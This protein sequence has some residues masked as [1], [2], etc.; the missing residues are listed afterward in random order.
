M[1]SRF[2]R[3]A[4]FPPEHDGGAIM[5]KCFNGNYRLE[6]RILFEAAAA[7]EIMDTAENDSPN[8]NTNET[9]QQARDEKD[10]LKNAPP[11]NMPD[12]SA[13]T[14]AA[15]PDK[16]G[17]IDA[18]VKEM[19]QGEIPLSG[20]GL[21]DAD[22]EQLVSDLFARDRIQNS[23]Q[24]QV[25]DS[26]NTVSTGKELV[27]ISS[28]LSGKDTI[29]AQAGPN[30][31]VLVLEKGSDGMQQIL[32]YLANSETRYDA[33]HFATKGNDGYFTVNDQRIDAESFDANTWSQIGSHLTD[34]GDLL[35]YGCNLAKSEAGQNL[36]S[37][38]ADASGADVAASTDVTG[39]DGN[40]ELEYSIGEINADTISVDGYGFNLDSVTTE[41]ELRTAI[42]SGQ[43]VITIDGDFTISDTI[44]INYSL[45]IDSSDDYTLT[46]NGALGSNMFQI[47]TSG[48]T[49]DISG[50]TLDGGAAYDSAGVA[51]D[52]A[53]LVSV[54]HVNAHVDFHNV[55][56]TNGYADGNGGAIT[57]SGSMTLEDCDFIG[58]AAKTHGG[59][60]YTTADLTLNDCDF[61]G[62]R[63]L[64]QVTGNTGVA[65]AIYFNTA[66]GRFIINDGLFQD[67]RTELGAGGALYTKG[68]IDITG[69]RFIDNSAAAA[70]GA[71]FNLGTLTISGATF[72][73]NS[74]ATNG[75]AISS[76]ATVDLTGGTTFSGN[77]ATGNGGV[78]YLYGTGTLDITGTANLFQDNTAKSGGAIYAR[79]D[80]SLNIG[81]SGHVFSS[82]S[83]NTGG[84]IYL[85]ST[86]AVSIEGASFLSNRSTANHGGAIYSYND[87]TLKNSTFSS[88]QA[89]ETDGSGGA[90][91]MN[92]DTVLSFDGINTFDGNRAV[93]GGAIYLS[94]GAV[95]DI[96]SNT[97]TF[98]GNIASKNGG[99]IF[100]AGN[101][102]V[103]GYTFS[104]LVNSGNSA[105]FGG[106]FHNA[107]TLTV[108]A[109]AFS[110]ITVT[111]NG[112]VIYNT[113]TLNLNDGTVFS[114][115]TASYG[116]AIFST[117]GPVS[118]TG[119]ILFSGNSATVFG[120]AVY[121]SVGSSLTLSDNRVV[122]TGNTAEDGGA[123]FN[124][125]TL[126]VSNYTFS[127]TEN[128]GNSA[129]HGGV[130]YNKG[131]LTIINSTFSGSSIT[132]YGGVIYQ[133][134]GTLNLETGTVFSGNSAVHGG[135][136]YHSGGTINFADG[137]IFSGNSATYGGAI[138]V[139]SGA[140]LSLENGKVLFTG[141]SA[142]Y[143]GVACN[144][145]SLTVSSYTF[146]SSVNS[147]NS[148]TNRGG[149]FYNRGVMTVSG[150]SFSDMDITGTGGVI[151]Q[152]AG[153]LTI[154]G[155]TVFLN[156]SASNGGAIFLSG[157]TLDLAGDSIRFDGNTAAQ[158]GGAIYNAGITR[159]NG[160]DI[161]FQG[162]T[163]TAT[164]G[165]AIY[166]TGALTINGSG[167][168]FTDNHA[169][170][171]GVGGS[172]AGGAVFVFG[173]GSF[174]IARGADRT[175]FSRN[176]AGL[177]GGAVYTHGL[178][179]VNGSN[180][181]YTENSADRDGGAVYISN[182][183]TLSM[184]SDAGTTVFENNSARNGGAIFV[185]GK[186]LVLADGTRFTGNTADNAGGAVYLAAGSSFDISDNRFVFTGNTA[187]SGGVICNA[188]TLTVANYTFDG[189]G[190]SGNRAKDGGIFYNDAG[191]KLKIVDSIFSGQ[192][193]TGTGGVIAGS[194]ELEIA[195]GEFSGNSADGYGG[196]VTVGTAGKLTISGNTV[197]RNN[198]AA[199][200]GAIY[201]YGS[202]TD[203]SIDGAVFDSNK[204]LAMHGGAIR[205]EQDLTISNTVFRDNQAQAAGAVGG[206][207]YLT[208]NSKLTLLDNNTFRGNQSLSSRGGAIHITNGSEV[209]ISGRGN[210]FAANKA[211]DGGA[212]YNLGTL[213]IAGISSETVFGGTG[214]A[215]GN[216]AVNGGGAIY[217]MGTLVINNTMFSYNA[218]SGHGGAIYNT[219]NLEIVNA[220]F[221]CNASSGSGGAVYST[222]SYTAANS[223]FTGNKANGT[224]GGALFLNNSAGQL[225]ISDSTFADNETNGYGGAIRSSGKILITGKEATRFTGNSALADGGAIMS[226]GEVLIRADG[227]SFT[228][229]RATRGGAVSLNGSG[230]SLIITGDNT[231]FDQN[232]TVQS[233][234]GAIYAV[235]GTTVSIEGD[236]TLFSGN[237]ASSSGGAAIIYGTLNITGNN[238]GF[239]GNNAQGLGSQGNGGAIYLYA[240]AQGTISG[241]GTYFRGNS[242]ENYG[243]A[244]FNAGNLTITA[245]S[246]TVFEGNFISGRST[247]RLG[248]G[249][250]YTVG[251]LTVDRAEFTGNWA[252]DT[253]GI[254]LYESYGGAIHI[255]G[256][257]A[258]IENSRF[259]DN[260]AGKVQ[261]GGAISVG[262]IETAG[263]RGNATVNHCYFSG[264]HASR[265]GG[266]VSVG[267][268]SLIEAGKASVTN[269]EF[270]QNQSGRHGGAIYIAAGRYSSAGEAVLSE[271]TFTGNYAAKDGGAIYV[272]GKGILSL[273]N[274]GGTASFIDNRAGENGGAVYTANALNLTGVIFQNNSAANGGAVFLAASTE[275]A[276]LANC[277]VTTSSASGEGSAVYVQNGRQVSLDS[278]NLSG[279]GASSSLFTVES[280]A[281]AVFG[282]VVMKTG[283][284][285]GAGE[286]VFNGV[287]NTGTDAAV[288][289][290]SA[291][292]AYAL[293]AGQQYVYEG[294]YDTLHILHAGE[295]ILNGDIAVAS[296]MTVTGDSV[297]AYVILNGRN[298]RV[299][300]GAN[301]LSA[302][303]ARLD[304]LAFSTKQTLRSWD[305]SVSTNRVS[306]NANTN[307]NIVIRADS[308]TGSDLYYGVQLGNTQLA[309]VYSLHGISYTDLNDRFQ[310]DSSETP[311]V[312]RDGSPDGAVLQQTLDRQTTQFDFIYAPEPDNNYSLENSSFDITIRPLDITVTGDSKT[313]TYNGQEQSYSGISANGLMEG[314]T[315]STDA[316]V[317][318]R[319]AG[320]YEYGIANNEVKIVDADGNDVTSNYH[321]ENVESGTL[322]INPA[323]LVFQ[324]DDKHKV[325]GSSDPE[326]T[327]T[328]TEGEL[329]GGD[330]IAGIT[331]EPGESVGK[332]AINGY[333]LQTEHSGNYDVS[334]TP[335]TLTIHPGFIPL[336]V[337]QDAS[338]QEYV[339]N[340]RSAMYR[341]FDRSDAEANRLLPWLKTGVPQIGKVYDGE[342]FLNPRAGDSEFSL[343]G[344]EPEAFS[345]GRTWYDT[346]FRTSGSFEPASNKYSVRPPVMNL[347]S[348]TDRFSGTAASGE[349]GTDD[350]EAWKD[351]GPQ[352]LP[353]IDFYLGKTENCR[354]EFD[355]LLADA[356]GAEAV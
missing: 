291:T 45:T 289:D 213:T 44:R 160:N 307:L 336:N 217:N 48:T 339:V 313:V 37:Q 33:I 30:R 237:K 342:F 312:K 63:S 5:K 171:K 330:T 114:G 102:T 246:G 248:G 258:L 274:T 85:N 236:N 335:G 207:V 192:H 118:M 284:N 20:H 27:I 208:S 49:V 343:G 164:H 119:E 321:F 159:I 96:S 94:A 331:R 180:V 109:S 59:A 280:G 99:V 277:T 183:G 129:V 210:I 249:A 340:G 351:I 325:H 282:D 177:S 239:I 275:K 77:S 197:F 332:Y 320:S 227:I 333:S 278:C 56:F 348:G 232:S 251:E 31:E 40:W 34:N 92:A 24:Y 50:I 149:L 122:F 76:S 299:E 345:L 326:L 334:F 253:S 318:G 297:S 273:T 212:I 241:K 203:S 35:F 3:W 88:N 286:Y 200:G 252:E 152:G 7:V 61:I 182:T 250:I 322:T 1:G 198:S 11:S 74:A 264:N 184:G 344:P 53:R 193:V 205:L 62:N 115:N 305:A 168:E 162:N 124:E 218:S 306:G 174:T 72:S 300:I 347:F 257:S 235:A 228:S 352:S 42:G 287:T 346:D 222:A 126:T 73:G 26:G 262:M 315:V 327:C 32:D 316:G 263:Q 135:A 292:A 290:S 266:A 123:I 176:T 341:M 78:F 178:F 206:A 155:G 156:N 224:G 338:T 108:N 19:I 167:T 163:A 113:G 221:S 259:I 10:A 298:S 15:Q 185:N 283:T 6:D 216:Q 179:T 4:D 2:Y 41:T 12:A 91:C 39:L 304:N 272:D 303:D 38:I 261:F 13:Q 170:S 9:E 22:T 269:S 146:S 29:A 57:S 47:G 247:G 69:T 68:T 43:T 82:N 127:G 245:A 148:A 271:N 17:D 98:T 187:L 133:G 229:N 223:A 153:T 220:E 169:L 161:T 55:T 188:G 189:T 211:V 355:R 151:A 293:S 319:N 36:L 230:A 323:K 202:A 302:G 120:G 311:D 112:A 165:G 116:G 255:A 279:A 260:G 265:Y 231:L 25:N 225:T 219:G 329:F 131:T 16:V 337:Y 244:V 90:I 317:S 52:G 58:N 138:Y 66:T 87:V 201:L 147:G 204:A 256:G 86:A 285:T 157:G 294:R 93:R 75:G 46:W 67:N 215:D 276:S 353:G 288:F 324:A 107:G 130:F 296:V 84:A 139:A 233:H 60:I 309:T 105:D 51:T 64:S 270:E 81:G 328:I 143:G 267:G 136:I 121:L 154:L 191:G 18:A 70:G 106:I 350:C 226:G 23:D 199:S 79:D 173:T 175:G 83:A 145:G 134:K 314:H 268:Y 95:L 195:G 243:G 354:N 137:I 65:G 8:A 196:A 97:V 117:G 104:S 240:G 110:D 310:L 308:V 54:V 295:K 301:A 349:P 132:G 144:E 190:N 140:S 100:N 142:E 186:P 158:S 89:H 150:S 172:G 128:S 254:S 234:G 125:G 238:T 209:L 28:N 103:S 80:A 194:G 242:G 356:I 166:T 21:A 214:G 281:K 14:P 141:N 101:L 111:G 181:T 71:I